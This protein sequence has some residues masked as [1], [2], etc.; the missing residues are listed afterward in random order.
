MARTVSRAWRSLLL[1][2]ATRGRS[3]GCQPR[4]HAA[5]TLATR[6]R[7]RARS[8]SAGPSGCEGPRASPSTHSSAPLAAS[9]NGHEATARS[10]IS[11]MRPTSNSPRDRPAP[12]RPRVRPA[13]RRRGPGGWY[14]ARLWCRLCLLPFPIVLILSRRR[15]RTVDP[16]PEQQYARDVTKFGA[17]NGRRSIGDDE[18]R[19]RLA[20]RHRLAGSARADNPTEV[21]RSLVA[22]HSTD[23]A[24]VF[25]ASAARMPSPSVEA[26]EGAPRRTRGPSGPAPKAPRAG[27]TQTHVKSGRTDPVTLVERALYEERSLVRILGMRRTLFVVPTELVPIVHAACTRAIAATQRRR[28]AKLLEEGGIAADGAAWLDRVGE[29]TMAALEKRGEAFG[30][31]LSADVPELRSRLSHGEGKKWAGTTSMTTWVLTLL[32]ADERIVRGRPRGSWL[33]SQYSW[34]PAP[35]WHD[36]GEAPLDTA[37]AQ[38]ELAGR[39]LA[40]FGPATLADLAWWTGWTK[41]AASAALAAVGAVEVD[42]AGTTGYVL[43]DDAEPQAAPEPWVALLPALDSTAMGWTDRAFYGADDKVLYD[44]SGNIAPTV[45]SDGRVVGCWAQRADGEVAVRL[46]VDTGREAA[47][48]IDEAA[49]RLGNWL[50]PARVKSRFRTPIE[51]ELLA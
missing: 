32:A 47:A 33:S 18:R 45:W 4:P 3:A 1:R 43:P 21:A 12:P 36:E 13:S 29:A 44:R 48:A 9:P 31:Q 34:S 2:A 14:W 30:A 49:A 10:I 24:T 50:G 27:N 7:P 8:T 11:S 51:R 25:L 26:I 19:A 35:R 40:S 28:Y 46:L 17:M 42:L 22:L 39:W 16:L 38:A 20:V 6:A 5:V 15:R 41:A 37:T 23:P